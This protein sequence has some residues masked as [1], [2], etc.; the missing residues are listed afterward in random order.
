MSHEGTSRQEF[1]GY[2]HFGP[3]KWPKNSFFA[4]IE[5]MSDEE[6]WRTIYGVESKSRRKRARIKEEIDNG[7]VIIG[8]M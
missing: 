4:Q 7:I 6:V 8:R 3:G 2:G 1:S 5:S